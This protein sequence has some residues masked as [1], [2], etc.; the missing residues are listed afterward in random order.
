MTVL[1]HFPNYLTLSDET[2]ARHFEVK[3]TAR[4]H[5]GHRRARWA[6]HKHFLNRAIERGD[7]IVLATPP[8]HAV[9]GSFYFMELACLAAHPQGP[10]QIGLRLMIHTLQ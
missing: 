5:W 2:L 1:G 8:A 3:S 9:P 4:R 6:E 7:R 10:R